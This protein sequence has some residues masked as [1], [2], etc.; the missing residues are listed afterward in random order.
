M[1]NKSKELVY[2]YTLEWTT[3]LLYGSHHGLCNMAGVL[4]AHALT[5]VMCAQSARQKKNQL[6]LLWCVR[7]LPGTTSHVTS[8]IGKILYSLGWSAW[9]VSW[10]IVALLV[11]GPLVHPALQS[12][13]HVEETVHP[14]SYPILKDKQKGTNSLYKYGSPMAL[15]MDFKF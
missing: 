11:L 3:A 14:N 1:Y 15:P 6:K 2:R 8:Y 9:Q 7:I 12:R 10:V 13:C 4:K 5:N